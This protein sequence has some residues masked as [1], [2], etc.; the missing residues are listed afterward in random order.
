[1]R[2]LKRGVF[3]YLGWC[4]HI[5]D[6]TSQQTLFMLYFAVNFF[7]YWSEDILPRGVLILIGAPTFALI[8]TFQVYYFLDWRKQQLE[9]K[10]LRKDFIKASKI[11]GLI[12]GKSNR[13][14]PW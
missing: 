1:M 2:F 6:T 7:L 9:L 14:W 11:N 3:L 10:K 13:W 8:I 5:V 12:H 4:R